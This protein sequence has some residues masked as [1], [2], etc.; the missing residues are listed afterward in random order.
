M[1]IQIFWAYNLS[2]WLSYMSQKIKNV[3]HNKGYEKKILL[4]KSK[5][6]DL[7][8]SK[9]G[10]LPNI[11]LEK[12]Y[13]NFYTTHKMRVDTMPHTFTLAPQVKHV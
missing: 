12:I 4:T 7:M 13:V 2:D 10:I 1:K 8:S 6:V 11:T 3:K 9:H 5:W